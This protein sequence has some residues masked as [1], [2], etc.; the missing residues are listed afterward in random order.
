MASTAALQL[1]SLTRSIGQ[2]PPTEVDAET[3]E[4][5]IKGSESDKYAAGVPLSLVGLLALAALVSGGLSFYFIV[6]GLVDLTS[7][8]VCVVGATVVL[9]KHKLR[10]L[11]GF[12][13]QHNHLR[14]QVNQLHVQNQKLTSTVDRLT[15]STTKLT[16]VQTDLDKVAQAS[17]QSVNQLV[18]IVQENGKLQTEILD[19][20]QAE[21]LGQIMTAVL[22]TD[23][24]RDFVL[25][26]REV[27]TLVLRLKNLPGVDFNEA[28]FRAVLKSDQGE[29]TLS[30]VCAIARNLQDETQTIIQ[31]RGR[32]AVF[33]SP[34]NK[35]NPGGG[36]GHLFSPRHHKNRGGTPRGG[37]EVG[38]DDK[39]HPIFQFKPRSFLERK[40]VLGLF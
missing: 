9:Q 33:E 38:S 29:L 23:A 26:K 18:D 40:K 17:G 1:W 4:T 2:V 35:N 19:H 10:E 22:A 36:R 11:G 3:G 30:D 14:A 28:A 8:L 20:L 12:R 5:T 39:N 13:G 37:G 34:T 32:G 31:S 6:S 27:E 24:D 25:N 21:V 15:V 16:K 7:V